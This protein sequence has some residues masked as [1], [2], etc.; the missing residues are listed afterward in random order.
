[1]NTGYYVTMKSGNRTAWLLGPYSDHSDALNRVGAAKDLTAKLDQWS[2]FYS[3]GTARIQSE[4]RLPDGK[5][6]KEGILSL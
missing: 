5:L 2:H 6:N 1:M 4:Q 3:F